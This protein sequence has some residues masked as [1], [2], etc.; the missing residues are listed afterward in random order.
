MHECPRRAHARKGHDYAQGAYRMRGISA[1]LKIHLYL[2]PEVE[3]RITQEVVKGSVLLD[4]FRLL[5][6]AWLLVNSMKMESRSRS[7]STRGASAHSTRSS[8]KS[9][10]T[11]RA[12]MRC[13][14][15]CVSKATTG[16]G[17]ALKPFA[18]STDALKEMTGNSFT[19]WRACGTRF[20]S[21]AVCARVS[22][23]SL[24]RSAR[25]RTEK[26]PIL[27]SW[28]RFD[29]TNDG[30]LSYDEQLRFFES[31]LLGF[32]PSDHNEIV[33]LSEVVARCEAVS[34]RHL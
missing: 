33:G 22:R 19:R 17:S 26:I 7:S 24:L 8:K 20:R 12:R 6:P 34:R 1:A 30:V 13:S 14:G 29:G 11:R 4:E 25:N 31:F 28:H 2:L 32:S 3:N 16:C 10:C 9:T 21:R 5:V 27:S 23:R 15:Y 18:C